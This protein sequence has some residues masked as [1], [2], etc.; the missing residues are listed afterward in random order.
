MPSC[1]S[2]A[3]SEASYANKSL[4]MPVCIKAK[5]PHKV[6]YHYNYCDMEFI[7]QQRT[8][9]SLS[10]HCIVDALED[11][12]PYMYPHDKCNTMFISL[13]SIQ[14]L[15]ILIGVLLNS[16]IILQCLKNSSIRRRISSILLLNQAVADMVNCLLYLTPL[17]VTHL[18][19][20]TYEEYPSLL[21]SLNGATA[22]L[23]IASSLFIFLIIASERYLSI[24]KPLWHRLKLRR[25][26]I[27]K[28][29]GIVWLLATTYAVV[30]FFLYLKNYNGE[31]ETLF[32]YTKALQAKCGLL[33]LTVTVIFTLTF[34]KAIASIR[35]QNLS[36]AVLSRKKKDFK[37][38][39]TFTVMYVSF[40]LCFI[41]MIFVDAS[42]KS[43]KNR[44]KILCFSL[45]SV[46][47]PVLTLK[48]RK[49]FRLGNKVDENRSSIV[50][51][52]SVNVRQGVDEVKSEL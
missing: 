14:L 15:V 3:P 16:I 41:P 12:R 23:S 35:G 13:V 37:L 7:G 8:S 5:K 33:I 48:L 28:S 21:D 4:L 17:I 24:V 38:T 46:I 52:V 45:T 39:A 30:A 34:C 2:I 19:S 49:D 29:I 31:H 27:W 11:C 22:F 44:L 25:A 47:N 6:T 51:R 40:F 50:S 26:R 1:L 32:Y 9:Y 18:Y 43:P 20:V 10:C 36:G 42:K